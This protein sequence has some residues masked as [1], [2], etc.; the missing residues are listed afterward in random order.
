MIFSPRYLS[1]LI[2]KPTRF[3]FENFAPVDLRWSQDPKESQIEI[4]TINNFN[5][6]KIQ[7]KPR[8]L[9]SRGQYSVNPVGLTDNLAESR[10]VYALKGSTNVANM[11]LVNGMAQILIEARNEGTCEKTLDLL[12]HFLTWVGPILASQFGFKSFALPLQVSTCTPSREDTEIFTCTV[13]LPWSREEHWTVRTDDVS[14]KGFI[15]N[16]TLD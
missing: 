5:K 14:L 9:V 3:F 1:S 11:V 4:D 15:L 16:L 10:G 2:I 12:Q 8:I 13:N 7:A 6:I